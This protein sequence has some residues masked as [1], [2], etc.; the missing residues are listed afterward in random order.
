MLKNTREEFG[1]VSKFFHWLSAITVFSMFGLG[2][3]MVDLTY[4]SAW[5][6]TAPHWHESAGV[7]LLIATILRLVWRLL[8]TQPDAIA[9]HSAQVKQ[10]SKAVHFALY[11]LLLV[12]MSSGFLM[13]STDGRAIEVFNWFSVSGLGNLIE[14]QE[15]LAGLIHEYCAYILIALS[16]LHGAAAIKHHLVD[17]D[18]TLSRMLK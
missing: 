6:K 11:L 13:S 16:L 9:T 8:S 1:L 7:L 12:L 14:N 10:A 4:Y 18:R 3:W 5:Y 15:D 2:F 17:K